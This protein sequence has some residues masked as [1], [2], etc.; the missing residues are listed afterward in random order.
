MGIN[1]PPPPLLL[2]HTHRWDSVSACLLHARREGIDVY[3]HST[4]VSGKPVVTLVMASIQARHSVSVRAAKWYLVPM[5][6]IW[7]A[8]LRARADRFIT[9]KT[10]ET[11]KQQGNVSSKTATCYSFFKPASFPAWLAMHDNLKSVTRK[12]CGGRNRLRACGK[13]ESTG[14]HWEGLFHIQHTIC[15]ACWPFVICL[16]KSRKNVSFKLNSCLLYI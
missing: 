10:S 8:W 1:T 11:E 16:N 2:P 6:K 4:P 7:K 12:C 5:P 3:S 14:L 13:Q 15:K 9:W